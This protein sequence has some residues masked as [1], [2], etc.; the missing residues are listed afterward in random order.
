MTM[1]QSREP[2]FDL[3]T[4][5]LDGIPWVALEEFLQQRH[6]EGPRLEYRRTIEG[7]RRDR[8]LR[9]VETIGAMANSGG[10]LILIGVADDGSGRPREWAGVE[11]GEITRQR[12]EALCRR[13]LAPYVDIEFGTATNPATQLDVSVVRVPPDLPNRPIFVEDRGILARAGESSVPAT[14]EQLRSWLTSQGADRNQPAGR[15]SLAVRAIP[16]LETP[17]L[18][19]A[20]TP[21]W[22]WSHSLWNDATIDHIESSLIAAFADVGGATASDRLIELHADS[23]TGELLRQVWVAPDATTYRRYGFMTDSSQPIDALRVAGEV[24]RTWNAAKAVVP[25]VLPGYFGPLS[26][27]IAI[28]SA[29]GGFR[30]HGSLLKKLEHVRP[31][32]IRGRDGWMGDGELPF[33]ASPEE[34]LA[35]VLP[36]MLLAHGY[37][38]VAEHVDELISFAGSAA[39][40]ENPPG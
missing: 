29:R 28:G 25:V 11:P 5:R 33:E 16:N 7:A 35:K 22:Y 38:H 31:A 23:N 24:R 36:A 17:I 2:T 32:P 30:S 14:V 20:V 10:G 13:A 37:R 12:I 39:A 6:Q 19:V 40:S 34:L 1:A 26:F 9:L 3:W 15:L 18:V 27:R 4:S 21:A 8:R